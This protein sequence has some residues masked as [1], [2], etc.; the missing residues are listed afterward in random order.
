[1]LDDIL[2]FSFEMLVDGGRLSMWMPTAD[3]EEAELA[4]PSHPGLE[5]LHV[6]V[7]HFNK[8]QY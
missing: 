3:D 1:M 7:Q 8:C 6:C 2:Q 5:L 4:T